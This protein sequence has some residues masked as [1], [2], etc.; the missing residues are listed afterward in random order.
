MMLHNF[1]ADTLFYYV[2]IDEMAYL[3]PD[4][5]KISRYVDDAVIRLFEEVDDALRYAEEVMGW[6][7]IDESRI[8]V[9]R[10]TLAHALKL[11]QIQGDGVKERTGYDIRLDACRMREGEHPETLST[12]YR[13]STPE[14]LN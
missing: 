12:I 10:A 7:E 4:Y 9:L 5:D 3:E 8:I 1:S 11:V 2:T 13:Y 14:Y 6:E